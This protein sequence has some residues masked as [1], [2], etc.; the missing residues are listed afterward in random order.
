MNAFSED[1]IHRAYYGK[2]TFY[3][4]DS[5]LGV[6]VLDFNIRRLE[7]VAA[8]DSR[9]HRSYFVEIVIDG[10]SKFFSVWCAGSTSLRDSIVVHELCSFVI[11]WL[12]TISADDANRLILFMIKNNPRRSRYVALW[13]RHFIF[14][15]LQFKLP[16]FRY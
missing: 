3:R 8:D 12:T 14:Q 16:N 5:T 6:L 9:C 11:V 4:A 7:A 1:L 2:W 15:L 10:R 13:M